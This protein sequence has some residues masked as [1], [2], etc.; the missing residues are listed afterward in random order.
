MNTDVLATQI[1]NTFKFNSSARL[2][3]QPV[4]K[5]L[6]CTCAQAKFILDEIKSK[7]L[8]YENVFNVLESILV[9]VVVK[10]VNASTNSMIGLK[11]MGTRL[12]SL[13]HA[14]TTERDWVTIKTE[15]NV[16]L[17]DLNNKFSIEGIKQYIIANGVEFFVLAV[18]RTTTIK[19]IGLS[20]FKLVRKI[21]PGSYLAIT[22]PPTEKLTKDLIT[23]VSR[24]TILA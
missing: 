15:K 21:Y 2:I 24:T 16:Y 3:I 12:Y 14:L 8:T 18:T 7:P 11:G 20:E 10:N 22:T 6:D 9:D 5:H 19:K 1:L 23:N 17:L 13:Q 4:A